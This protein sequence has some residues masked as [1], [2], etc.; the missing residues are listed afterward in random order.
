METR[1]SPPELLFGR[2]SFSNLD[3]SGGS[4]R[5]D[6]KTPWA[7]AKNPKDRWLGILRRGQSGSNPMI[8]DFWTLQDHA[9]SRSIPIFL[10]SLDSMIHIQQQAPAI[11]VWK[12]VGTP[13]ISGGNVLQCL[14]VFF[15]R[16]QPESICLGIQDI[17]W[18][19]EIPMEYLDDLRGKIRVT[20]QH[21]IQHFQIPL[22][23]VLRVIPPS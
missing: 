2:R 9:R 14:E 18:K 8:L 7:V 4:C 10:V 6:A 3:V 16:F 20:N 15:F 5:T 21:S 19:V 13:R 17:S 11:E 23:D 22:R 1:L 12:Y